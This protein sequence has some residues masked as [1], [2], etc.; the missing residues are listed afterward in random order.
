MA[1][2][3]LFAAPELTE[4]EQI[5]RAKLARYQSEG[6]DPYAITKYERT[7]TSRQSLEA[8]DAL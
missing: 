4:Q 3:I 8:F 5:R 1:E 6:N 2:E 7:H